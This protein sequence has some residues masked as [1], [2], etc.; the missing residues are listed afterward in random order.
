MLVLEILAKKK[1]CSLSNTLNT[2]KKYVIEAK[3]LSLMG[4]E[5]SQNACSSQL[6]LPVQLLIEWTVIFKA[7]AIALH[8]CL[9]HLNVEFSYLYQNGKVNLL[10]CDWNLERPS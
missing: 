1:K 3:Q 8:L 7:R 5:H 10:P 4:S 2:V 6:I 9:F